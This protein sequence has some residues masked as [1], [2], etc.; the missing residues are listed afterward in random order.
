MNLD[1][2]SQ[3]TAMDETSLQEAL[4]TLERHD[5]VREVDG[6]YYITVELFRRWVQ[7]SLGGKG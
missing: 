6:C 5:V 2:L 3:E 7:M 4:K 1:R